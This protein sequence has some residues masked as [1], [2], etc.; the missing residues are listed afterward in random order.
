MVLFLPNNRQNRWS[1]GDE[2]FWTK[3]ILGSHLNVR[4]SSFLML[5]IVFTM[6]AIWLWWEICLTNSIRYNY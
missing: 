1:C 3:A 6:A 4:R 5:N 2:C